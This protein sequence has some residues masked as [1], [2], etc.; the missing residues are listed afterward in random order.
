MKKLMFIFG[1]RPEFIKVYPVI[2]E[3]KTQGNEVVIVNTGQQFEM[4]NELLAHFKLTVDYDLKI[5]NQCNGLSDIVSIALKGLDAIVKLEMP[6]VLFVHGDTSSTLAGALAGFYNH[7][8]VAHI[9]AGLR[10]YN[11]QSPFPEE[12]N[13]QMVGLIANY[14]FAPTE[15]SRG[16]LVTEGKAFDDIY[17]VGN[18][19]IDTLRYTIKTSFSHD[20][21]DWRHDKKLI[22]MTIHRRE[23]LENLEQIFKALNEVAE[24]YKE[25]Y[26]FVY[27]IH[28]NKQIRKMADL[29]LTSDNIL[30]IEPMD[31]INF[32]NVMKRAHLIV[33]D[34][35]GIQE[36]A[37]SLGIP[38][39][40][41]RNTTE[42]PEGVRAG[43]LKLIGTNKESITDGIAAV[44]T[45][46]EVYGKMQKV[47]NPYGN[48]DT[49][50]QIINIINKNE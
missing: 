49:S 13:R 2:V 30:I 41:V 16:N 7:V 44:L 1:T 21:L 28:M 10:T 50:E 14:H 23:N 29:Y 35:G 22:L 31:T 48:G 37:P 36:E 34:S 46:P 39:L 24:K 27:P 45:D 4:V 40:V 8:K 15:A 26:K 43:S 25:M 9:E 42:R 38:V 33:T 17:V 12:A 5:M 47:K 19:A 32:H 6:D 18:S 3:A 20:V 11:I